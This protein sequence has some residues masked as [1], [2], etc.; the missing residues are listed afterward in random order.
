MNHFINKGPVR[1]AHRFKIPIKTIFILVLLLAFTLI[2]FIFT[3]SLPSF[4]TETR[5]RDFAKIDFIRKSDI[6]F[7]EVDASGTGF[8]SFVA[9]E[10]SSYF[11]KIFVSPKSLDQ[12]EQH[13]KDAS[14]AKKINEGKKFA[15]YK[16]I[17]LSVFSQIIQLFMPYKKVF[18]MELQDQGGSHYQIYSIENLDIDND[19]KQE[20]IVQWLDYPGGSGGNF[21]SAVICEIAGEYKVVDFFPV[22]TPITEESLRWRVQQIADKKNYDGENDYKAAKQ[23][24]LDIKQFISQNEEDFKKDGYLNYAE[25]EYFNFKINGKKTKLPLS[26]YHTD[27]FFKFVQLKDGGGC[28]LIS[29]QSL[30]DVEGHYA[31][32]SWALTSFSFVGKKFIPD[33]EFEPIKIDKKIGWSIMEVHGYTTSSFAGLISYMLLPPWLEMQDRSDAIMKA[34]TVSVVTDYFDKK[35]SKSR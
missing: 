9:F 14:K 18:E 11:K 23:S 33:F 25:T 32:Q 13:V 24:L 21:I 4:N 29:A 22:L 5:Y 7:K 12:I 28:R 31:P 26:S 19:G 2:Y 16:P 10:K 27:N 15:I 17:D 8:K 30:R 35:L 3:G 20:L 1:K 34:R 6:Y